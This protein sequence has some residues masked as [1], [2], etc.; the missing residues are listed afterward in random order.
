MT[1]ASCVVVQSLLPDPFAGFFGGFGGG[2]LFSHLFGGD[3][4]FGGCES[5][6]GKKGH[7]S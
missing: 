4:M 6:P 1:H 3:D 5:Y 2:S 7:M